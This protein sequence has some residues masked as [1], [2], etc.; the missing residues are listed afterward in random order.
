MA[1]WNVGSSSSHSSRFAV[2]V[3]VAQLPEKL[4][5]ARDRH[6]E[7]DRKQVVVD[8]GDLGAVARPDHARGGDSCIE[9]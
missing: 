7:V 2:P 8:R 3:V 9:I 4:V 1:S 5:A 6:E